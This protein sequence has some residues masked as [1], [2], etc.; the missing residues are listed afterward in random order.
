MSQCKKFVLLSLGFVVAPS[1]EARALIDAEVF[2]GQQTADVSYFRDTEQKT[3]KIVASVPGASVRYK[4]I[5]LMPLSMGLTVSQSTINY[6][7][8]A[9]SMAS[10]ALENPAFEGYGAT[11]T[12]TSKTLFY[13]PEL[14]VWVPTP[15]VTPFVKAAYLLGTETLD[16]D[17]SLTSPPGSAQSG[18]FQLNSTN[19][20]R[21]TGTSLSVGL[22]YS[23]V[24]LSVIFLEYNVLYA[25]RKNINASGSAVSTSGDQSVTTPIT[26]DSV[27][28]LDKKYLDANAA[29]VR[30]G[31]GI[32][33]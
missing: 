16:V 32:G 23:P 13:G 3:K 6:N 28:E 30:L 5:P 4:P 18:S 29:G 33:I 22:E 2:Y 20:Y 24:K 7:E 10:D 12:G 26:F 9:K 8:I 27:P 31:V 21:H 25:R 15:I 11:A 19:T 17:F 14:K 1:P